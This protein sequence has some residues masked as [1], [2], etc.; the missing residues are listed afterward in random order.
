MNLRMVSW[1]WDKVDLYNPNVDLRQQEIREI[2]FMGLV[3]PVSDTLG[4]NEK[5]LLHLVTL[6][7]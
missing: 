4:T 5:T 3:W 2:L 6:D 1:L 7:V